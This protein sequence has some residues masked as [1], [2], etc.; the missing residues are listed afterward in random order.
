[1]KLIYQLKFEFLNQD[2]TTERDTKLSALI[3]ETDVRYQTI[4]SEFPIRE[5]NL[6]DIIVLGGVQYQVVRNGVHEYV[7][8]EGVVHD[9]LVITVESTESIR[10]RER[11]KRE[12]DFKIKSKTKSEVDWKKHILDQIGISDNDINKNKKYLPERDWF[13]QSY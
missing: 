9:I 8:D 12:N 2:K 7:Q 5:P 6:N 10:D 13:D 3:D 11:I 1:M 4:E